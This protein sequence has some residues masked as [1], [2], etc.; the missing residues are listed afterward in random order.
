MG[1]G[2]CA[3]LGGNTTANEV[4]LSRACL[5]YGLRRPRDRLS[6]ARVSMTTHDD[7]PGTQPVVAPGML[8]SAA[9]DEGL[10][11]RRSP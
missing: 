5:L 9:K 3:V 6:L 2:C 7:R 11:I 4:M 10:F 1:T 8:L